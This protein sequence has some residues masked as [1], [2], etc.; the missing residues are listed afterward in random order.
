MPHLHARGARVVAV[1]S[2]AHNYS[3]IDPRDVDFSTYA[4]ASKVYGNA[5]RHLM[6]AHY[7]WA[8]VCEGLTLS[9]VHP[10]ISPTTLFRHFPRWLQKCIHHP[11]KWLFMS[12]QKA[13][14][15]VAAGCET[16]T[17]YHTWI[18]PRVCGIWGKPR[19]RKLSRRFYAESRTVGDY[20]DTLFAKLSQSEITHI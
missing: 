11:M 13:A 4:A 9:V 15:A 17:P 10:G 2:I 18:G 16:P 14:R 6:F 5:K 20:A 12:P 8:A 1:G 3:K 19:L 7:E